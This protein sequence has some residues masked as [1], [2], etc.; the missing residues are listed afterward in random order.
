M[1]G[2]V[3]VASYRI[4]G[5]REM[6]AARATRHVFH[7]LFKSRPGD[8]HESVGYMFSM[9]SLEIFRADAIR[10]LGDHSELTSKTMDMAD[11]EEVYGHFSQP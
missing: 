11:W 2:S 5:R 7:N 10:W 8:M 9:E 4:L 6:N 3:K 1:N